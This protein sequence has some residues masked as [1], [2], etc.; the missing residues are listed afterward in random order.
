LLSLSLH[1]VILPLLLLLEFAL[2]I[3]LVPLNV[4]SCQCN[5]GGVAAKHLDGSQ[6]EQADL[7]GR[8]EL[9]MIDVE[10]DDP[11]E[12]GVREMLESCA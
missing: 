10:G 12:C 9:R 7:S 6:D 11:K 1:L 8:R 5:D 3:E 4:G 2:A